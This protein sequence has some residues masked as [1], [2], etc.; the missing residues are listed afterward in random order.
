ME[1]IQEKN[2]ELLSLSLA[3]VGHSDR[4]EKKLKRRIDVSDPLIT[5]GEGCEGK[6]IRLLQER[7]N[8]L[9]IK[10]RGK[11]VIQEG[12]GLHLIHLLLVSA[13]LINEN[14]ISSAIDNLI[15][16]YQYVSESGDSGQRVAAYFADGLTARILTRRSPFYRLIMSKPA[17]AEEFSAFTQLYRVSPFYQFAHFTANQAIV[18][19]FER[20]EENN[21]WALHVIDF[22]ILHG[23]QWPS[24]IQSLSEEATCSNRSL[25]LRITGFG[26]SLEELIETE[27]RLVSFSKSF[28]N[29]NF[30]FHGFLRGLKLRNLRRRENETVVVNLVFHLST[31]K[32]IL[33]ISDTLTSVHSLN[34]SIVVL[35]EREGSRNRCGFL[36]SYV[37]ALHYYAAMF[38]SLDDCL[39]LES[40]ERLSIEKN[41]LGK[42]IK[43]AIACEK[44]ETNYLRFEMLETW[45]GR[46]ET[47]G[48]SGMK[49][50][51]RAT[52]QAKLLLK[53]G[54]HY[55]THLEE[56]CGGGGFRVCERD[57]GMALSLGW[58]VPCKKA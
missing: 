9:N 28:Q 50:S 26:R 47:H 33:Q 37:D 56:D 11:R 8:M 20:Q 55:H 2:D 38:D 4:A 5:S 18:E 15:E 32:D 34:P 17:P 23:F 6:I 43:E 42:E 57:D 1:A 35:V 31:L 46:M 58:Q 53:M 19:A 45:R 51:S 44:D 40:P 14:N 48:F 3:I 36:S 49:L 30:E 54:S 7:Q 52:I 25:S 10:Q 12:K 16:L 22:D 27:A 24:L 39:P 41:H 13:T 29:I 21:N